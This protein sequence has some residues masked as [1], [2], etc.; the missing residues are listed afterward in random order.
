MDVRPLWREG[1]G[2]RESEVRGRGVMEGGRESEERGGCVMEGGR[3]A[4]ERGGGFDGGR[5]GSLRWREGG[6]LRKDEGV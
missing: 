4:E 5:E 3:E 1:G 2:G 6:S